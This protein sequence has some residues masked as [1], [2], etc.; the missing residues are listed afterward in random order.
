MVEAFKLRGLAGK[1]G[2]TRGA[3]QDGGWFYEYLKLFPGLGLEV[4]LNF[5]GNGLPEENR[6]VALRAL[7][8]HRP[9][10]SGVGSS[11]PAGGGS[12]LLREIPA[13]LVAECYNDL[14]TMAATGAGFDPEWEK[15]AYN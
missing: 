3:A 15:K 4:H 6:T 5:T 1:L 11:T 9:T 13:V 10:P 8:F 12:L 7:T 2:Y 14:R